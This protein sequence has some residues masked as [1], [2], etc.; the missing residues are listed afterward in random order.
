M[1]IF[2]IIVIIICA[3]CFTL[4]AGPVHSAPTSK[5]NSRGDKQY[6]PPTTFPG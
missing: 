4:D 1:I 5:C 6:S 3:L 2:L